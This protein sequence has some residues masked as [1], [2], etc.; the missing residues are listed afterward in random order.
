MLEKGKGKWKVKCK[1]CGELG[2]RQTSSKCS[3]NGTKKRKR[4][5]KMGRPQGSCSTPKTSQNQSLSLS[6]SHS[7]SQSQSQS[8]TVTTT[9]PMTRRLIFHNAVS[10]KMWI[11]ISLSFS[12]SHFCRRLAMMTGLEVSQAH[13]CL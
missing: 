1:R 7:H 13:N 9:S 4:T 12:I 5:A 8:T 6:Q 10:F 2:H 11:N 3:L